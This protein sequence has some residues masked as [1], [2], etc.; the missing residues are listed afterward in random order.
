VRLLP[1]AGRALLAAAQDHSALGSPSDG[2]PDVD[3]RGPLLPEMTRRSRATGLTITALATVVATVWVGFD[4]VL[5]PAWAGPFLVLR[6]L[7]DVPM[8]ICLWLLWR[9]PVGRR[10]PGALTTAALAVVQLEVAWMVVRV[11]HLELYLLGFTLALYCSGTLSSDRTRWTGALAGISWAALVGAAATA[12]APPSAGDLVGA[13]F[14]LGTATLV[15][16]L[17]HH[18]RWELAVGELAA[19]LR[20]ERE[21]ERTQALLVRLE[22]LSN[23]DPLTGLANRRR[24]DDELARACARAARGGSPVTLVLIDVDHFKQINDQFGHP[25]GD[26]ALR[27]LA[28][29]LRASVRGGDL[30][31]RIGGDELAVLLPGADLDGAVSLAE[32]VRAAAHLLEPEGFR[33][34]GISISMGVASSTVSGP[35]PEALLAAVDA[36]LY[37]AKQTRNAVRAPA[38]AAG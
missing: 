3:L 18:R 23:E 25:A 35:D 33:S 8:L 1:A 21:R 28:D 17:A 10:H 26:A 32:R 5:E 2:T 4:S 27:A 24:W 14:F 12:P 29:L 34:T 6:L 20:L 7:G 9:R 16:V 13:A 22:R 19:R 37:L 31:A 38:V 30:A 36:Q 15:T 11:E